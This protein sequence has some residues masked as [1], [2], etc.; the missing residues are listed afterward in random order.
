MD[1]ESILHLYEKGGVESSAQHMDGVFAVC[2]LDTK[3]KELHLIRD[4]YGVRPMFRICTPGG[5]L[6]V[7]SEA[8]GELPNN[9]VFICIS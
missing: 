2:L 1:G 9:S 3:N 5:T 8:K 4:T 6:A 7:C